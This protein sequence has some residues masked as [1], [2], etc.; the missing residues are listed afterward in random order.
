MPGRALHGSL[1]DLEGVAGPAE[2][3]LGGP[4]EPEEEKGEGAGGWEVSEE[5][6]FESRRGEWLVLL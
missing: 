3:W 5:R 1:R 2:Q 6:K 4:E